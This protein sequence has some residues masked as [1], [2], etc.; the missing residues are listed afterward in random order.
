MMRNGWRALIACFYDVGMI[1]VAWLGAFWLRFNLDTI[2]ED[3]LTIAL[4]ALPY[5]IV[6]QALSYWIF[7]LYR[8]VWRFA[9]LP[10][11]IRICKAILL[12][13]IVIGVSWFF[14]TR[15]YGLPR[16]ILPLYGLLLLCFLG[17]GRFFV[18]WL[19][20]KVVK[21][22]PAERVLIVGAGVAGEGLARELQRHTLG[23]RYLPVGFIDDAS[24]KVGREILGIR[25]LGKIDAVVKIVKKYNIQ[26][27]LIALPSASSEQMRCVI[28][29]CEQTKLPIST[30]PTVNDLMDGRISIEHLRHLSIDDLLGR[31]P[32]TLAKQ[33]AAL[34]LAN[35]IVLVSGGGGSIGSELCR[36]LLALSPKQLIVVDNSEY[37]LFCLQTELGDREQ[38][39]HYCLADVVDEL[40]IQGIIASYH[41]HII[42]H[43]AAFKHV[44]LLEYQLR[45]ALRNNVIGTQV[46]ARLAIQY[47]VERFVLVSTDKAVN[48]SS[49]MGASKRLAEMVCQYYQQK[50]NATQ[51]IIVRFGNVLGSRGSVIETFKNQIKNGG[52]VTVTHPEVTRYFMTIVEASQLIIQ[53]SALAERG[54]IYVLDMGEPIKIRYL[55]EQMIRLA[56]L[57]PY[58]DIDIQYVGLRPGE[59]IFE[60]L[61]HVREKHLPTTHPKILKARCRDINWHQFSVGL[62]TLAQLLQH[63]NPNELKK[64]LCGLV[65]EYGQPVLAT[66]QVSDEVM[67]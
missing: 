1:P 29:H 14:Y 28:D 67:S 21:S 63:S 39:I 5:V 41:P 10:D 22:I 19:K 16:S 51:F 25:V 13:G 26:R 55:A 65:P 11:L 59:K 15:L 61:F 20:D 9:S 50:A 56:G 23:K 35:K 7:N 38:Q 52:P 64:L 57:E 44:P 47:Q 48:P 3:D 8:G 30:L 43:A 58:E 12:G 17:G 36:Q 45:Q 4:K 60:E 62:Q 34:S 31:S 2:P 33:A 27:I 24:H 53:A 32:I 40:S 6:V 46:M 42:Y 37:H 18:R 66:D 54:E 49:I